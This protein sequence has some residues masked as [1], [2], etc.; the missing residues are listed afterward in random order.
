MH[1]CTRP[2]QLA[3]AVQQ[4]DRSRLQRHNTWCCLAQSLHSFILILLLPS[5]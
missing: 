1:C 2:T 5:E 3:L 4:H